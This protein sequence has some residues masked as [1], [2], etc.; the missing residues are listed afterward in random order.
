MVRDHENRILLAGFAGPGVAGK[1][2]RTF[3]TFLVRLR[4]NGRLDKSFGTGGIV[5]PGIARSFSNPL[6]VQD[7]GRIVLGGGRQI[8]RLMPSGRIDK[9]FFDQGFLEPPEVLSI[10]DLIIDSE[11]RVVA[12]AENESG[13]MTLLRILP[14]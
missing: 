6:V 8:V 5:N 9:S 14:G 13:R 3:R 4:P 10:F 7:D 12:T 2:P 1:R 11:K